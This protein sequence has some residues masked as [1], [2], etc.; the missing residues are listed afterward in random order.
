MNVCFLFSI[1]SIYGYAERRG[2][3]HFSAGYAIIVPSSE[4]RFPSMNDA[5]APDALKA[6]ARALMRTAQVP[7]LRFTA[8]YIAVTTALSLLDAAASR[9]LGG[10]QVMTFS[11]SFVSV[12]ITLICTVVDAG[13]VL[14]CLRVERGEPAPYE[15]LFD[16]FPNAGRF[17]ALSVLSGILI[18]LGLSLFLVPGIVLMLSYSH[19][20]FH[21]CEEPDMGVLEALRRSRLQLR[22]YKMRLL[23]LFFGFLPLLLPAAAALAVVYGGLLVPLFPD[24]LFGDF[25]YVLVTS[26]LTGSVQLVLLPWLT[27]AR[28]LFYRRVTAA[29]EEEP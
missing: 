5:L 29:P 7:P 2:D 14:Y 26:L 20:L 15:T 11:V 28:V 27:L 9:T 24:T 17:V 1:F 12:L 19:A 6:D 16:G 3:L 18:G 25:G 13:Y 23:S 4:G 10:V 8:L 21:L 22:G